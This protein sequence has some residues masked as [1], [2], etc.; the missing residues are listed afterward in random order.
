MTVM[1]DDTTGNFL[2][3]SRH[4]GVW[5]DVTPRAAYL[6]TVQSENLGRWVAGLDL[7]EVAFGFVPAN[8]FG[9]LDHVVRLPDGTAFYNP[10]RVLPAGEGLDSCELL[11][12]VRRRP[13]MTDEEF[14]ADA[15]AVEADLRTLKGLLESQG[16]QV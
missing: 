15:A 6:F 2:N 12:T 9:V 11:F 10:M 1:S 13:G 4:V 7:S 14:D 5:V 8:D 3:E 16:R